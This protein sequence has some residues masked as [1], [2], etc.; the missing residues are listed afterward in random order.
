[1]RS[2]PRRKRVPQTVKHERTHA[3]ELQS[4]PVRFLDSRVVNCPLLV[5]AG[6]T[7]PS[8]NLPAAFHRVSRTAL[9]PG[10]TRHFSEDFP[11]A[12]A[13]RDEPPFMLV[14]VQE[15]NSLP[16]SIILEVQGDPISIPCSLDRYR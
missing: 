10:V 5:G 12:F 4:P 16:S 7:K 15:V 8:D 9:T 1:V 13:A 6:H 11:S 2:D 14:I 3:G